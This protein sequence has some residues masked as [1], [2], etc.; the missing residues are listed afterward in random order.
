[1]TPEQL[2]TARDLVALPGWRWLP[3]MLDQYGQRFPWGR[4]PPHPRNLPD[5]TD[6]GTGGVLLGML[7]K[8]AEPLDLMVVSIA[9]DRG[10]TVMLWP[11]SKAG[12]QDPGPAKHK[13]AGTLA[14]ACAQALVAL[15]RAS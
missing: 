8:L 1:M 14:H 10:W 15:G 2:K 13:G 6:D 9:I 5:L 3:G 7:S 12:A 4:H 11:K